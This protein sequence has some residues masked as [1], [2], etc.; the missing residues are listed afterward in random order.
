MKRILTLFAL[1]AGWLCAIAA[2]WSVESLPNVQLQDHTRL[3]VNPD[4]IVS[5]GIEAQIDSML[6][7]IR[8]QTSAEVVAVMIDDFDGSDIDDFATE[9]FNAWGIGKKDNN[10]GIL[11]LVAKDRKRATIRTGY[12]AEGILPDITAGRIL[13]REMFPKFREGDYEGGLLA[14]V[15]CVHR[16]ATDPAASGELMSDEGENYSDGPDFDFFEAY[17]YIAVSVAVMMLIALVGSLI[18]L[19]K[20]DSY[21]K[22]QAL[23][24]FRAWALG[25]SALCMFIPLVAAVPLIALLYNWRNGVRRCPQCEAG[26]KKVDEVHDNDYL[27]P[28]Q[29]TEERL[30]SIDYDVWLCPEC[31]ETDILAYQVQG[32]DYKVCPQCE[33]RACTMEFER[34]V[35][36]P[37]TQREGS[38]QRRFRCRNCA[39]AYIVPFVIPKL[40]TPPVIVGGV[41]RGGRGGGFGGSFGG[42]FGGGLTGGGG[43]SGGW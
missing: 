2:T 29:D 16:I 25:L 1:L 5:R 30:K 15:E 14:A 11:I 32:S 26:M 19:R 24:P 40:A 31:G 36:N 8:R 21:H 35:R 18:W 10:N 7:D 41:G 28:A 4:G 43:A 20:K 38:G 23:V 22:Y 37:T 9:L 27:S 33:A 12:G 3:L 13:R 17:L 6:L 42:G 39:Y 34:I